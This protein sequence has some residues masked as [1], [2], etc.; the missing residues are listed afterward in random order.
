MFNDWT[1]RS[2]FLATSLMRV[3]KPLAVC[4]T[5]DALL[6]DASAFLV[7]SVTLALIESAVCVSEEFVA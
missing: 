5:L 3:L 6:M 1:V 7:F 2:P 4:S